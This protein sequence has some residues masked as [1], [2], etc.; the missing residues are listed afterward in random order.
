MPRPS[1]EVQL[2]NMQEALHHE[3]FYST[4][5]WID[6][7][8]GVYVGWTALKNSFSDGM[9]IRNENGEVT[10]LFSG[11]EFPEANLKEALRQRRHKFSNEGSSYLVHRYEDEADFP[12]GLNG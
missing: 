4:G 7:D 12:K 11:E 2:R 6:E 9:P 1:A 5:T 8:L 10:L 3:S